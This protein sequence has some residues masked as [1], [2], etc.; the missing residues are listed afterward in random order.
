M[1]N[2]PLAS[3]PGKEFHPSTLIMLEMHGG[4]VKREICKSVGKYAKV[5]GNKGFF[6][7]DVSS[8]SV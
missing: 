6:L 7:L 2:A 1:T 4:Q 5:P 8:D 3:A